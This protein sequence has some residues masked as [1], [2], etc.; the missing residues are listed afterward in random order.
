MKLFNGPGSSGQDQWLNR[1]TNNYIL[2]EKRKPHDHKFGFHPSSLD[3]CKRKI[4]YECKYWDKKY[5]KNIVR[6]H[7][8]MHK[9]AD[10]GTM[11]HLYI[12]SKWHHMKITSD[13]FKGEKVNGIE[14]PIANQ[15]YWIRGH[16]DAVLNYKNKL[17]LVDIKTKSEGVF[18]SIIKADPKHIIQVSTYGFILELE[19]K[20]KFNEAY[21]YYVNR[22]NVDGYQVKFSNNFEKTLNENKIL[23][24]IKRTQYHIIEDILPEKEKQEKNCVNECSFYYVCKKDKGGKGIDH[25]SEK[26]IDKYLKNKTEDYCKEI[27]KW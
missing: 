2:N 1:E 7:I 26:K 5:E 6:T 19:N 9:T 14:I 8:M 3:Q 18:K 20:Q 23:S 13:K 21:I 17:V 10:V 27:L 22:N 24:Y 15:Q 16:V 11:Q 12:Q 4:Y 25:I